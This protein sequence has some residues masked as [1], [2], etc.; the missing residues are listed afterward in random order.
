MTSEPFAAVFVDPVDPVYPVDLF[1]AEA[2]AR[3][4]QRL[5]VAVGYIGKGYKSSC[6]QA[7]HLLS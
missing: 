3:R 2:E 1:S 5:K 6:T 7:P 4:R